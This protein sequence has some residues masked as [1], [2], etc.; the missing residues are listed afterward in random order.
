MIIK[1]LVAGSK[2]NN[3][4]INIRHLL[5]VFAN[6]KLPEGYLPVAF[7]TFD[8]NSSHASQNIEL[9]IANCIGQEQF[10]RIL[11]TS[12]NRDMANAFMLVCDE[13]DQQSMLDIRDKW[14]P[15]ICSKNKDAPTFLVC[16]REINTAHI[17][18]RVEAQILANEIKAEYIE[19]STRDIEEIMSILDTVITTC[20]EQ[21]NNLMDDIS[22]KDLITQMPLINRLPRSFSSPEI[23]SALVPP[24]NSSNA[25][26]EQAEEAQEHESSS[27]SESSEDDSR[28]RMRR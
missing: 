28:P 8:I 18:F 25:P 20:I 3:A 13:S 14:Y 17:S 12:F 23:A 10:P 1:L 24:G 15:L 7:T 5:Y 27:A 26:A 11:S 21:E 2:G 4:A 6:R 9:N 19:C 22:E 16:M